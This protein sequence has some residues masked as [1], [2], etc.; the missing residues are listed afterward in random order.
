[1]DKDLELNLITIYDTYGQEINVSSIGL[2]G[3]KLGIPSPSYRTVTEEIDGRNGSI[4]VDRI[5]N[6][7]NLTAEFISKATD[8]VDSLELRDKLYS[9]LGNGLPFYVSENKNSSRRWKVYLED[10]TPERLDVRFHRFEVPLYAASGSSESITIIKKSFNTTKFN[11][12]NQGSIDIDPRE[13]SETEIEFKGASTDLRI[14]N[15]TTGEEWSWKGSTVVGDSI[16]LKGVRFLKNEVSILG[17]SNKKIITIA[18]GQNEFEL[19]GATGDF[20]LII[21]SR[22]YFL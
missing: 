19:I 4:I 14:L 22:F 13:H 2:I 21:R 16:L 20:E 3:M 17:T 18:P 9:M 8:Y 7:R 1:M 10:W 6:S 11:F 15:N 12:K 5:L